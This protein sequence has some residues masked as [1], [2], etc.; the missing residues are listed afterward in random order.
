MDHLVAALDRRKD[1]VPLP[2]DVC[3]V[4]VELG[5]QS[6]FGQNPVTGG[7]VSRERYANSQG[8]A[9]Y[10]ISTRSLKMSIDSPGT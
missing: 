4:G 1:L 2:L 10:S 8:E 9:I 3:P 6:G 7:T 5:L